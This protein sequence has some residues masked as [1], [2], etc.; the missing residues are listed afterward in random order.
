[1]HGESGRAFEAR[2]ADYLEAHGLTVLAHRYRCRMGELDLVCRDAR[3]LVIVEVRAR[4]RSGY[5]SAAE[6]IGPHKRRRIILATRHFLLRHREWGAA[7]IR[8]DVVAFDSIDEAEPVLTWIKN[9][10]EAS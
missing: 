10:F 7:P 4:S 3:H 1:M 2:A 8:F 6:S 5:G 9:A